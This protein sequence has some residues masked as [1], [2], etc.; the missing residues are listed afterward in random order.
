M[1]KGPRAEAAPQGATDRSA[2]PERAVTQATHAR[3]AP[4]SSG[5]AKTRAMVGGDGDG[6]APRDAICEA[7]PASRMRSVNVS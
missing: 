3:P 4:P 7:L 5:G 1:G 6:A 2:A